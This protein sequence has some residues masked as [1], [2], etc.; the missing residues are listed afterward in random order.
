MA[1]EDIFGTVDNR[2][3]ENIGVIRVNRVSIG[4]DGMNLVGHD[5]KVNHV[6]SLTISTGEATSDHFTKERIRAK[7]EIIELH[8]SP[9]Q[10][11]NL[12]SSFGLGE[13][14]P[15]TITSR[16]GKRVPQTYKSEDIGKFYQNKTARE[17]KS[18][19]DKFDGAMENAVKILKE[20][21][22][23][24]KSDR[25]E[26]LEAYKNLNKLVTDSLPFMSK[27]M[28]EDTTEHITK[29]ESQLKYEMEL[30]LKNINDDTL[31]IEE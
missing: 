29:A 9:L 8:F 12:V 27:L 11:G 6:I 7:K 15:T 1:N 17:L 10:W 20:K 26:I 30:L 2:E 24:S 19:S 21:K 13:G 16:D 18:F 22:T 28:I 4:G 23:I 5:T 31:K 3:D 14:V 25:V